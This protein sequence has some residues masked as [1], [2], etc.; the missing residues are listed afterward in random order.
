MSDKLKRSIKSLSDTRLERRIEAVKAALLQFDVVVE[1]IENFK[2]TNE[3]KFDKLSDRDSVL[4]EMFRS[5]GIVKL[6]LENNLSNAR[7]FIEKRS[8][9]LPKDFKNKRIAKKKRMFDYEAGDQP[10]K[11]VKSR[12]RLVDSATKK[13]SP[14]KD[15][16][17][18]SSD[19][20]L[21][22]PL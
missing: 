18:R 13:N 4:N 11:P 3:T 19:Q 5:K 8:Y 7:K 21:L 16:A 9:D 12:G 14:L 6:D 1:C 10:I 17:G 15:G 2:R 20:A 22:S